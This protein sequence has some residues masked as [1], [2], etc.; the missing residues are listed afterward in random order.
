MKRISLAILLLLWA[1]P[2]TFATEADDRHA[3]QLT[4]EVVG[5]RYCAGERLNILQLTVRLRYRNVGGRKLIVYR[6]KNLFYQTRI[7]GG[8]AKPYEVLV[9]N[10]RFNDA[11]A[12]PLGERRPGGAFVTL[13]PG[14]TYETEVVV[15]VGV[16]RGERFADT[17]TPGAH[18]LQVVTSSW[19]ESRRRA[20]ELRERWRGAG[21][22]WIEPVAALP[23][24]FDAVPET[25]AEPCR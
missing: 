8:G 10:S 23:V 6:G 4:A 17:I 18:T 21:L 25:P 22:L 20:E 2:R 16:A 12:E 7:R 13:R 24:S 11:E 15:G 14:G 5:R 3:L 9:T 19:Y 1:A